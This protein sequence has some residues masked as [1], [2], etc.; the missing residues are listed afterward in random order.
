MT[1]RNLGIRVE[2]YLAL[3]FF[4]LGPLI[5]TLASQ[6]RVRRAYPDGDAP[7][8]LTAGLWCN[9]VAG[10]ALVLVAILYSLPRRFFLT[11]FV[12]LPLFLSLLPFL[13]GPF[14]AFLILRNGKGWV[15]AV[16]VV[17]SVVILLVAAFT[18]LGG[19]VAA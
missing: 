3:A 13:V 18:L 6:R 7:E 11:A 8:G 5:A 9:L 12:A 1:T 19:M 16:G 4:Y 14:G 17:A 2:V 10:C 15:R